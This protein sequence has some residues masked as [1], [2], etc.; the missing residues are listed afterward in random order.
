MARLQ[1]RVQ[2][3]LR[4]RIEEQ[5]TRQGLTLTEYVLTAIVAQLQRDQ[6]AADRIELAAADRAWFF[7]LLDDQEPL[8]DAWEQAALLA[9]DIDDE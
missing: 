4:E 1:L 6:Q 9:A 3:G 7:A 2:D 8:P 5:A